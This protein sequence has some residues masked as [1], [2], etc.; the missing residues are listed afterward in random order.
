MLADCIFRLPDGRKHKPLFDA[1]WRDDPTANLAR[2][3]PLLRGLGSEWPCVPFGGP[4][5]RP[6]LPTFWAGPPVS[7]WDGHAHGFGSN[8]PW[9]LDRHGDRDLTA[10]IDYREPSP[11]AKLVRTVTL[12]PRHPAVDLSLTIHAR[13]QAK[14]PVAL[15]PVLD[16][17]PSAPGGMRLSFGKDV[18]V[19]TL[20][21]PLEPGGASRFVPDSRDVPLSAIP[22]VTGEFA[23]ARHLPF[24]V[25]SEDLAMVI[26]AGG[27]VALTDIGRGIATTLTWDAAALPNCVLWFSNGG[28]TQYPWNGRVR[29]L[30]IEPACAA[31]DL[32]LGP[33]SGEDTPLAR[34]GIPSHRQIRPEEPLTISYRIAIAAA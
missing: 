31:F 6:D 9:R 18:R 23:D 28:R 2:L 13:R 32:G 19:W 3:P 5:V 34:A 29:C 11:V 15:H 24:A 16:L 7:D 12:D 27:T 21:V 1:P 26:D 30:G 25:P 8:H 17:S 10:H 4:G 14:V 33:S 20:P 22:L